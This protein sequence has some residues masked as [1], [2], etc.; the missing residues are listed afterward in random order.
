MNAKAPPRLCLPKRLVAATHNAGK[1]REIGDLLRP[2]G[3]EAVGSAALGLLEPEETGS[4]FRDNAVLKAEAAARA[5]GAAALADDSGLCVEALGGAPGVL[6]AR[7]AGDARD[8]ALAM[9]RIERELRAAR[10]PQPWRAYFTQRAG[11]SVARRAG[12]G[13]RRPRRRRTALPAEGNARFWLRSD[14]PARRPRSHL[15]RDERGGKAR[16]AAGWLARPVA[17]GQSLPE[18]VAGAACLRSIPG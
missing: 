12:R 8:F 10:A 5:S 9:T 15:R 17:P 18:T 2:F 7:W 13:L 4:T 6:S 1:L 11:A 3:I 16:A 14:I